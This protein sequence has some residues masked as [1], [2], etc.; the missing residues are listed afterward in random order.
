MVNRK[1]IRLAGACFTAVSALLLV[2]CGG[3]D[4]FG[5][6]ANATSRVRVIN[7]IGGVAGNGAIDVL[8]SN[9]AVRL[10]PQGGVAYGGATNYQLIRSGNGISTFV[11]P[12]GT[13]SNG[14][15]Q[16][17]RFD[18]APHDAGSN[19][20]TYTILV[21]G[22]AGRPAGSPD[23]PQLKRIIDNPQTPQ[24]NQILLRLINASPDAGPILLFNTSGNPPT[25]AQIPGF[26]ANGV[27][28]MADTGW[29]TI[30]PVG[31]QAFN[32]SV[33]SGGQQLPIPAAS[34]NVNLQA[35]RA[36]SVIVFGMVNPANGGQAINMIVVQDAPIT[37]PP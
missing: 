37:N 17:V 22:V 3:S 34:G 26:P 29:V 33:Q 28:Y 15:I 23:I 11:Y 35:G 10:N 6:S 27:S 24:A 31:G 2:G 5:P 20:G 1:T 19:N 18:L 8:Q 9:N 36:Y 7:A 30:T 12:A 4:S 32:L 14:V 13:T 21:S 16:D 25:T